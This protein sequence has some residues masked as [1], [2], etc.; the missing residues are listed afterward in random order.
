MRHNKKEINYNMKENL[1]KFG[2][3]NKNHR[4]VN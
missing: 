3:K 2:L 4:C 1:I